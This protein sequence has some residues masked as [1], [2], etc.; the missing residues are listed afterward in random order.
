MQL[1]A[2]LKRAGKRLQ[3]GWLGHAAHATTLDECAAGQCFGP[4]TIEE[5]DLAY[6]PNAWRA[7]KR[8]AIDENGKVRVCDDGRSSDHNIATETLES[9]T[10]P[11]SSF[12]ATMTQAFYS[13]LPE[14]TR[15]PMAYGSDD[16]RAA[17]RSR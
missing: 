10:V 2:Q 9:L 11:S 17:Y 3:P 14:G 12:P 8:F 7:M 1:H 15:I 16:L 6:G 13:L 5:M 4:F